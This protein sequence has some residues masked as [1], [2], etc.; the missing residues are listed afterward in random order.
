MSESRLLIMMTICIFR[1][2]LEKRTHLTSRASFDITNFMS[3]RLSLNIF[4]FNFF[5]FYFI[6]FLNVIFC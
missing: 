5:V 1:F 6:F 3:A 2:N 4:V